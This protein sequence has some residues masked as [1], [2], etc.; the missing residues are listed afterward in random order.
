MKKNTLKLFF[1]LFLI[2]TGMILC[3]SCQKDN[4]SNSANI[5]QNEYIVSEDVACIIAE[6][7]VIPQEGEQLTFSSANL[8]SSKFKKVKEIQSIPNEDK[9]NICYILNYEGGGFVI[10]SADKR[11]MPVLAFSD[12]QNLFLMKTLRQVEL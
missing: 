3:S 6:N 2:I 9:D 8:K 10:L 4:L 7:L 1:N 12:I 5:R 11:L